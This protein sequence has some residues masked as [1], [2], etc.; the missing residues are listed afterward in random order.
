MNIHERLTKVLFLV[1]Y[2]RKEA[3]K[4]EFIGNNG[5]SALNHFRAKNLAMYRF[6]TAAVLTNR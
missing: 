1:N 6:S 5:I 4:I 3:K 2:T